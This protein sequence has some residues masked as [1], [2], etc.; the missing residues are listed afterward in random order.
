MKKLFVTLSILL[1]SSLSVADG[2]QAKSAGAAP[3]SVQVNVCSLKSGK[4]MANYEK[5]FNAYVKWAKKN[6]VDLFNARQMPLFSHADSQ[7][8]DGYDFIDIL[9][10]ESFDRQ[11]K[12]WDLWLNSA[13]GRKLATQWQ[14]VA[15]CHVKLG[16]GMLL[17][18]TEA[19]DTD[20]E[21]V[22][23]WNWC[24][25]KEGI[26][27]E[28]LMIKHAQVAAT[29]PDNAPMIG[30]V[31]LVPTVGGAHAPG[32]FA[33]LTVYPDMQAFMRM[34]EYNAKGGWRNIRDYSSYADCHGE[35]LN[36]ETIVHRPGS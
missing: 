27:V 32:D 24:S 13:E 5:V 34:R 1:I 20:D 14:A 31:V 29:I 18:G 17:Y 21:R 12:G 25:A 11:G 15:N 8:P 35:A 26:A 7:H 36:V 9:A 6:D 16:S 2:H 10:S 19:L 23:S 30:W 28:Q 3:F 22:V 33:H 4:S